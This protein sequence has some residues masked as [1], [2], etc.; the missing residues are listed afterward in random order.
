MPFEGEV[1]FKSAKEIKYV[2][3]P[4]KIKSKHL[5]VVFSGFNPK[6]TSPAYNYIR[7]LQSLQVNKLFILD[8]YGER[9]CY[10]LGKNRLFDIESSVVSL[11]TLIANENSVP[12]ENIICC[13]SSKG[14]YASLYF[15]IKYGFGHVIVGAPQTRLGN[16][17][18]LA[19]EY[20]TLEFI[21]GNRSEES[22]NFLDELLFNVVNN[23]KKVPNIVIHVGSGDHHY[24]GHVI[25]FKEHLDRLGFKCSLDIKDYQNHGNVSYYQA[26]LVDTLIAIVPS[27][28]NVVRIKS[29]EVVRN[30]NHFIINTV[31]NKEVTYAWYVYKDGERIAIKWYTKE[32]CY[33]YETNEPGT[34]QFLSFVKD[35]EETVISEKTE[36]Y[37]IN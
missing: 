20:P 22:L 1:I 23:A 7:T 34:Y 19:K 37:I 29:I 12:H 13:G 36:Q 6:G 18:Y 35:E 10:Y 9:G 32:S 26:F 33:E 16:Y 2:F 4:S 31:S 28:N 3:K 17:L 11:I 5:V 30:D 14:G 25:P 27:L 8:D 15:G 24:K 21:A